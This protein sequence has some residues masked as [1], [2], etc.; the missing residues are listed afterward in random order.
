LE[1]YYP[2]KVMFVGEMIK[3]MAKEKVVDGGGQNFD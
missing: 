3:G 2:T 1:D